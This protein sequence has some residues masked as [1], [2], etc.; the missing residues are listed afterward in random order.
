M[1]ARRAK[2]DP[3]DKGGWNVFFT[4]WSGT[5]MFNPAGHLS[6]RGNGAN[7]WLAGQRRRRSRN[8]GMR[9]SSASDL[10]AQQKI[11]A[12]IQQQVLIDVP[13]IPL[14]QYFTLQAYRKSLK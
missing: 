2:K 7:A 5:D 1:V 10:A 6:L 13:Y 3:P 12:E 9:G 11:C 14:G 8:C 4:G